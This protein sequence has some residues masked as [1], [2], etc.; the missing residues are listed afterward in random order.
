MRVARLGESSDDYRLNLQYGSTLNRLVGREQKGL[1]C[2]FTC[3][4]P[5]ANET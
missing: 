2:Q 4:Q 3:D 5:S 1:S